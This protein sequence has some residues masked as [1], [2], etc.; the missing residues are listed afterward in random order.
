MAL[1]VAA[2][3]TAMFDGKLVVVEERGFFNSPD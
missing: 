3:K 1:V 2:W